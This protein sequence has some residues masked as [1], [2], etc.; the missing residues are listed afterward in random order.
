MVLLPNPAVAGNV[1]IFGQSAAGMSVGTLLS[2][3]RAEGLFHRAIAQSGAAHYA[4]SA[5][6]AQQVR[7]HLASTWFHKIDRRR[8]LDWG[9]CDRS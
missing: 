9:V 3:P 1:A 6:T 2:M 7:E 5:A 4:I 8:G